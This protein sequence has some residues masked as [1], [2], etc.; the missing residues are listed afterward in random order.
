M[1][2]TMWVILLLLAVL[3]SLYSLERSV[4][5]R[6]DALQKHIDWLHSEIARKISD[7]HL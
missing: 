5:G 7:G 4:H 1:T 3:Y 2:E 6:I